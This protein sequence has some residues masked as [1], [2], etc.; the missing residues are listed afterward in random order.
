MTVERWEESHRTIWGAAAGPSIPPFG[1]THMGHLEPGTVVEI[2]ERGQLP[3]EIANAIASTAA[4][5]DQD[6]KLH[7]EPLA[8][9][10]LSLG[11]A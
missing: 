11:C 1:G 10:T 5:T 7:P 9:L 3:A 6:L 4:K 8:F 2:Y